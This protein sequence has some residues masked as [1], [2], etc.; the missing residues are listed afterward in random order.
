MGY[1]ARE[2]NHTSESQKK[3]YFSSSAHSYG[4]H[5]LEFF[6]VLGQKKKNFFSSSTYTGW[7]ELH[8]A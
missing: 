4:N 1:W 2:N 7:G 5:T 3:N 8:Y 6:G